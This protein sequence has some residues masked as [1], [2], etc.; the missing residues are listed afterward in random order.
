MGYKRFTFYVFFS[1]VA[2]YTLSKFITLGYRRT[3]GRK[4][5]AAGEWNPFDEK[6]GQ[7]MR[8]GK[9]LIGEKNPHSKMKNIRYTSKSEQVVGSI[10][11]CSL[12]VTPLCLL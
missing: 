3:P 4:G 1:F 10:E 7:L 9:K 12:I 11:K 6:E 2:I 8:G 5:E